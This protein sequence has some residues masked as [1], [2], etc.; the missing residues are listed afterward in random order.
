MQAGTFRNRKDAISKFVNIQ[1]VFY[2]TDNEKIP[3]IMEVVVVKIVEEVISKTRLGC[4]DT[5]FPL[6]IVSTQRPRARKI[7]VHASKSL[8]NYQNSSL[9]LK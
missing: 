5:I 6:Y 2:T 9:I 8:A 1:T 4:L 7:N 3:I